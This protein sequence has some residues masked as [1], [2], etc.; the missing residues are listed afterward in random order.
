MAIRP[1]KVSVTNYLKTSKPKKKKK[2]LV[3]KVSGLQKKHSWFWAKIGPWISELKHKRKNEYKKCYKGSICCIYLVKG[4][5]KK[6]NINNH[7]CEVLSLQVPGRMAVPLIE[8]KGI[9]TAW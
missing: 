8:K 6:R 2:A 9:E 1:H 5:G 4:L 3:I 7:D